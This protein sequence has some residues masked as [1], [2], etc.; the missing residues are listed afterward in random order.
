MRVSR[1]AARRQSKRRWFK[2][3]KGF[4][5]G[6]SKLLRT[7]KETVIRAEANATRDRRVRKRDF[8]RLWI[9]RISAA[10][11]MRGLRYSTFIAGLNKAKIEI[12]RRM[13]AE[14]AVA[15]PA[16]FDAVVA[17]VKEA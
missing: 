14:M 6:R 11:R 2:R 15:D 5:G 17:K 4:R 7:V 8:R 10:C 3:A 12:D 9:V 16:A 13:L 1:G